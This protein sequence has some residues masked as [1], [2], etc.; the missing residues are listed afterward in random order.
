[1][2]RMESMSDEIPLTNQHVLLLDENTT[3]VYF[4]LALALSEYQ[5]TAYITYLLHYPDLTFLLVLCCYLLF[6]LNIYNFDNKIVL[7]ISL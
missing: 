2:T 3:I 6:A 7:V 5:K 1:M 4:Y